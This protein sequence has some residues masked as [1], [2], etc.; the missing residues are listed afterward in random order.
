MR[1]SEKH[2]I[3]FEAYYISR[4]VSAV[5]RELNTS[6]Q[7]VGIW[8]VKYHWDDECADRDHDIA[9]MTKEVM[10]PAWV[11]VKAKLIEAFIAQ[12]EA[13]MKAGISPESSRDMVAISR[14]LRGLMGETEKVEVDI[15]GI[16]YVLTETP[17]EE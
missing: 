17:K 15:P 8:K 3:A 4:N 12:I 7:S 16:E 5:A 9:E 14:E 13:A 2:R 6:R 1:Q 10:L 11:K